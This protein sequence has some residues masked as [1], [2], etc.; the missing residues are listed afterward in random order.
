MIKYLKGFY[1]IENDGV[2][3]FRWM[4]KNAEIEIN[5]YDLD[6]DNYFL[7][8][9][10][11]AD[12]ETKLIISA[13]KILEINLIP[14]WQ[15]KFI[16][17]EKICDIK[18]KKITFK[19][20]NYLN[21]VNDNRELSLMISNINLI[22]KENAPKI[23]YQEGFY[24]KENDGIRDFR[25]MQNKAK[26]IINN[27][28]INDCLIMEV[29]ISNELPIELKVGNKAVTLINGW[30]QLCFN[31]KDI[32]NKDNIVEINT[33]Y[34]IT[35]KN[36]KRRLSLMLSD[37][38]LRKGNKFEKNSQLLS[39]EVFKKENVNSYPTFVTYETSA[40]CNLKCAM[41]A[42]DESLNEFE[43]YREAGVEKTKD[44][45][46]TMLPYA[47]KIQL[48]ASG[49]CLLGKDFWI[50]LDEAGV[51]AKKHS[52]EIEIFTNGLLLNKKNRKKIIESALTDIV[53]SVDAATEAT[54][55]K[56]R[57][58]NFNLLLN[59]IKNLVKENKIANNKKLRIVMAFVMMRE[60]IEELPNFVRL[61]HSLGVKIISFWPLFSTGIDMPIKKKGDFIFYYKQQML[62]FYPNLMKNMVDESYKIASNLGVRIGMTPCFEKEYPLTVEN[63]F[64]YP[65]SINDF[66]KKFKCDAKY[67]NR[68]KK[69]NLYRYCYLPWNTA[70]ITTE[71]N[72]APCLLLMY[73]GGIDNVLGKDFKDVWNSNIMKELRKSIIEGKIH[74][75]CKGASCIFAEEE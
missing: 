2:R 18:N 66:D 72:F 27:F 59:N 11:A 48:H 54:Y 57:G 58:G 43:K 53:I 8:F 73:L 60:N 34:E 41:C 26:L 49:E 24:S 61:A 70:F 37:I 32:I 62:N 50:S 71:G 22:K 19:S 68:D 44:V 56:I 33:K 47:S 14:G 46:M 4:Q 39:E 12:K 16:P 42:V 75:L 9:D 21:V 23:I 45:Y 69:P 15:T 36:E 17:L 28:N 5:E 35:N 31:L 3:N 6:E 10:V 51:F 1:D 65:L 55:K 67:I 74:P 52:M 29:G 13:D 7:K 30:Q 40:R 64:E 38:E 63:D 25:W 20:D